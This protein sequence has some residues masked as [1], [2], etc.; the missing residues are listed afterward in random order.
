MF[1]SWL[2]VKLSPLH[3][4]NID[5]KARA[6][7]KWF[8]YSHS[9]SFLSFQIINTYH[10]NHPAWA[11][12]ATEAHPSLVIGIL[13]PPHEVLV[14]HEVGSFIDHEAATLHLDGVAAAEVRVKVR[15]VI[16]ALIAPTLEV[17]VLVKD[18]LVENRSWSVTSCR[19]TSPNY[20]FQQKENK[21]LAVCST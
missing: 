11:D 2:Y 3:E 12:T 10:R 8:F 1:K 21:N 13:S 18:N 6:M 17:L 14:A 4:L 19:W 7:L 15:A 9:L 5:S 20:R 16:A